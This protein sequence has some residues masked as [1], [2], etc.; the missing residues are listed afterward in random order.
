MRE[1][2]LG[3]QA[4]CRGKPR[5]KHILSYPI[6]Y[7]AGRYTNATNL[8]DDIAIIARTCPLAPDDVGDVTDQAKPLALSEPF[9]GFI[10]FGGDVDVFSFSGAAG[11][12]LLVT[13][14]LVNDFFPRDLVY[15][16]RTNLDA[17]VT[18]LN[19][20]G[21][22]MQ[23][24]SDERTPGI[25][26]GFFFTGPLP[27]TVRHAWLVSPLKST[28]CMTTRRPYTMYLRAHRPL[29]APITSA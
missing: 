24:L 11:K 9:E 21:G 25:F 19:G 22:V 6:L 5:V 20:T 7:R 8:E 28:A 10:G 1:L 4:A 15:Y 3:S 13:F 12:Q 23:A 27:Y 16:Q 29:R 14:S 2:R 18:L 26:S 17:E